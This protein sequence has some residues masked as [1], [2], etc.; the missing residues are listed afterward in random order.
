MKNHENPLQTMENQ[1]RIMK[2]NGG[3]P[4]R[5]IFVLLDVFPKKAPRNVE[6]TGFQAGLQKMLFYF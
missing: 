3:L 2:N 1:P 5:K 4:D 6:K